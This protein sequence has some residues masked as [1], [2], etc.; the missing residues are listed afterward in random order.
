MHIAPF[1]TFSSSLHY[2]LMF[3][4]SANWIGLACLLT[5][6]G[7]HILL[8]SF[9]VMRQDYQLV[10]IFSRRQL[11]VLLTINAA[12]EKIRSDGVEVSG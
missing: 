8:Q 5:Y 9:Q 12:L 3:S 1:Q 7:C 4:L 2:S 6:L 10:N 11:L